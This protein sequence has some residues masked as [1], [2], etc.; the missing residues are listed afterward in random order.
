M[1]KPGKVL[2]F[3]KVT[4]EPKVMEILK[5]SWKKPWKVM[6]FEELKKVQRNPD[7]CTRSITS[8]PI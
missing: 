1:L 2:K 4:T 6:E 5:K 7:S 8:L 3:S